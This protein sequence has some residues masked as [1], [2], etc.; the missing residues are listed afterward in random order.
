[1]N[2]KERMQEL[3]KLIEENPELPIIPLVQEDIVADG[4]YM[5]WMAAWGRAEVKKYWLGE[6][7]IHFYE[8]DDGR[9]VEEVID[10]PATT[11]QEFD[12]DN[13]TDEQALAVYEAKPWAKAIFVNIESL[14]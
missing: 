11:D 1:M 9:C 5:F 10:D 3:L 7:Q 8:P 2:Q 12:F 6:T 13:P 4:D 14:T